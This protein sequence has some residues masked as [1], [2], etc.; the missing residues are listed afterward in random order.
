MKMKDMI[1]ADIQV[2]VEVRLVELWLI[3][4]P[5][6]FKLFFMLVINLKEYFLMMTSKLYKAV[7][8]VF[9]DDF[10]RVITSNTQKTR[11]VISV[12]NWNNPGDHYYLDIEKGTLQ[13][14]WKVR[15]WLD[16][17]KHQKLNI[18]FVMKMVYKWPYLAKEHLMQVAI[19]L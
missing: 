14:L 4:L 19:I 8:Q 2:D 5:R 3:K 12:S 17:S 7:E 13:A 1:L 11:A 10:V 9:P 18:L 15:P 6:S 16:R